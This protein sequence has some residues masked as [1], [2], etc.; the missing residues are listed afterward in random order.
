MT[1]KYRNIV[2]VVDYGMG[3]LFSVQHACE[4]VGLACKITSDYSIIMNSAGLILPGVGSFGDAMVNLKKFDLISPIKDFIASGKPFM[5][6]CLGMQLLLSESEEFGQHKGLNIIEGSVLKFSTKTNSQKQIKV[7]QVGWNQVLLPENYTKE[8]WNGSPLQ[9]I[10][11]GEFMY[12]V[13]SF[14]AIPEIEKTILSITS[15]E[16]TTYCSSILWRNVFATQFHPERSAR[17]G[18]K[19]YKYWSSI[20]DTSKE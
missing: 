7:P 3:N 13:H 19:I 14:Y 20:V 5:G 10:N 8:N 6:I 16:G 17:E 2:A 18:I 12:F 9:N 11:H 4:K 1:D 15:Y